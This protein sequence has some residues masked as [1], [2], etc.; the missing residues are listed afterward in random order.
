VEKSFKNENSKYEMSKAKLKFDL[1]DPDDLSSFKR[2][3]RADDMA[4]VIWEF[5]HNSRKKIETEFENS[6]NVDIYDGIER[7]FENFA[8]LLETKNINIDEIY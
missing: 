7:C 3:V 8:K 6:S 5:V 1:S 2:M 4:S